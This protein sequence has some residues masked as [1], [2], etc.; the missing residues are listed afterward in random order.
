MK[1]PFLKPGTYTDMNGKKVTIKAEDLDKIILATKDHNYQDNDFPLVIGHPKT[2]DPAW[3]WVN[4]NSLSKDGDVLVALADN[5]KMVPEFKEWFKKK[6]FKN[7]SVKLR[8]DFSIA[9][10]GFLGAKA[11]A[12]TGLPAVAF[13]TEEGTTIEFA[14]YELSKWWFRTVPRVFRSIKN[15]MIE[16]KGTEAADKFITVY[17]LEEIGNPP[18]IFETV[19]SRPFN[20]NDNSTTINLSEDEMEKVQQLENEKKELQNK[21]T[22]AENEKKTLLLGQKRKDFLTFCEGDDVKLKIKP[23]EKQTVVEVLLA[24]DETQAIE[25]S[26]GNEKKKV[27]PVEFVQSLLKRLPDVVE[28]GESFKS[29]G[30]TIDNRSDAVKVGES[31]AEKV[32]KK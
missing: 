1:I 28:L 32:N 7:V 22:A 31:I 6:L 16:E 12:V 29:D 25:F 26:E 17:D 21:L 13:A 14:E 23:E 19:Q 8:P 24:L 5:E 30:V 15:K 9:H 20:E 2:D 10:I 4:K 18:R 11:P 3:G 27:T